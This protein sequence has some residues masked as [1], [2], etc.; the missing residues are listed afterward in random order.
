[1]QDFNTLV[2]DLDDTLVKTDTLFEQILRLMRHKPWYLPG[3]LVAL[4]G[5]RSYFKSFLSRH[6]RLDPGSLVY[7]QEILDLI[8]RLRMGKKLQNIILASAAHETIVADVARHT[9]VFD[10]YMGSNRSINLKGVHK[11]KAIQ[12]RLGGASFAYAGDSTSDIPIWNASAKA[13]VVNPKTKVLKFLRRENREYE[14]II[15]EK[16]PKILS[17]IVKQIRVH[18]WVKNVLVF[19]PLIAAHRF[20]DTD[21]LIKAIT[22]FAVFCLVASSVYVLNDL[23]DVEADRK[24]PSKV[25]R[26]FASGELPLKYGLVLFPVLGLSAI[27]LCSILPWQFFL[28]IACYWL[29]NLLYSMKLKEKIIIDVVLLGAFYS[30]RILAGGLATDIMPSPWL[31]SFST[32]FF[33]GLALVKRYTELL[34]KKDGTETGLLHGRG[35]SSTDLLP[36]MMLGTGSSLLSVIV[37]ALYLN[38]SEIGRL[39]EHPLRLWLLI[40]L[41]LYWNSRLWV[42]ANRGQVDDDPVIFAL[43]DRTT[44]AA[45]G[46][47]AVI[48]GLGV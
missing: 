31:L 35:Y 5:G 12:N 9:G 39:Y 14:A 42:I 7:R 43:K 16:R 41:M 22:A 34:K 24:H 32:F 33:F 27:V 23:L 48:T 8:G 45:L 26:P 13:F 6:V 10:D 19:V 21:L 2:I 38:S 47:F 1:M 36:V 44:W 28:S 46:I 18:Q 29:L 17:L 40:P 37:I 3:A 15:D 20:T 11:L 25:R 4:A 30:L